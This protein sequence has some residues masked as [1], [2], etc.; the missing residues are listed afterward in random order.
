MRTIRQNEGRHCGKHRR[1]SNPTTDPSSG[2]ADGDY[3]I[4]LSFWQSPGAGVSEPDG[5]PQPTNAM[6]AHFVDDG[7]YADQRWWARPSPTA[8]GST[9]RSKTM[10]VSEPNRPTGIIRPFAAAAFASGTFHGSGPTTGNFVAPGRCP[11]SPCSLI[12]SIG[13]SLGGAVMPVKGKAFSLWCFCFKRLPRIKKYT[14][15]LAS[16]SGDPSGL[17][18]SWS[19]RGIGQAAPPQTGGAGAKTSGVGPESNPA[20]LRSEN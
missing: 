6:F 4:L 13:G 15:R 18:S 10:P 2:R 3:T 5:S 11:H 1:P 9:A 14:I 19:A 8:A 16:G 12:L 17:F 20:A 7:G